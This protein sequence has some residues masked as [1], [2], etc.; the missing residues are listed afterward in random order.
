MSSYT[1]IAHKRVSKA[2]SKIQEQALKNRMRESIEK[3]TDYPLCLR[4]LDV[5]KLQGLD[6]AFRI[7]VGRYRIIFHVDK[8]KRVIFVT[9]LGKRESVY[10]S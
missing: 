10:E 3:L 6:R 1:I 4:D 9:H 7:R 5:E 2:L 8:K